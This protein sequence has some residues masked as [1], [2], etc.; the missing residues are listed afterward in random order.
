MSSEFRG[1]EITA[2]ILDSEFEPLRLSRAFESEGDRKRISLSISSEFIEKHQV[3]FKQDFKEEF[4]RGLGVGELF[5][6]SRSVDSVSRNWTSSF[7][8]LYIPAGNF[9]SRSSII[10]TISTQSRNSL[11]DEASI[12]VEG[13][14]YGGGGNV[15]FQ[16]TSLSMLGKNDSVWSFDRLTLGFG[17]EM[18]WHR[19]SETNSS[20][21]NGTYVFS[22]QTAPRL[23]TELLSVMDQE[24]RVIVESITSF[25]SFRRNQKFR[26]LG[27]TPERIRE[28]GGGAAQFSILSGSQ[29][30]NTSQIEYAS[31]LQSSYQLRNDIGISLGI[32]YENQSNINDNSNFAP[33]FGVAWKPKRKESQNLLWSLPSITAGFGLFYS[34]FGIENKV[35]L[36]RTNDSGGDS[37][38]ITD[39]KILDLFPNRIVIENEGQT[40]LQKNK[41]TFNSELKTPQFLIGNV[42]ITKLLPRKFVFSL[43]YKLSKKRRLTTIRNI[44]SP[45]A[46]SYD[47]NNGMF[48]IFPNGSREQV[49]DYGSIG[50]QNSA[51]FSA[52]LRFPRL[53]VFF[54]DLSYASVRYAFERSKSNIVLGS[55]SPFDP[56][57]FR[58]EFASD[59][60]DGIHRFSALINFSFRKDIQL[61]A[62]WVA[63]TGS[64]FNLT[65]GIDSNG[66]GFFLERPSFVTDRLIPGAILTKYGLLNPNPL[67]GE[68]LIPRNLGRGPFQSKLDLFVTKWLGFI[69]SKSKSNA[70]KLRLRLFAD[71]LNVL[72]FN[73]K[74]TPIGNMS[75]PNFLESISPNEVYRLGSPSNAR[76]IRFGAGLY[77]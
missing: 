72:N 34:R 47:I 27:Y 18:L 56:Y 35:N 54:G 65:T 23:N 20:N 77:F 30:F 1:K 76:R 69:K 40:S 44:N 29:A 2:N 31:Y 6:E 13:A 53:K 51:V 52:N 39:P 64:R 15:G 17:G 57:D 42:D 38:L 26:Q 74:S 43:R 73:G 45:I 5:L 41:I 24:G 33:R 19:W 32:R 46:R 21:V 49:L 12:N 66:D 14:F 60:N 28:F 71:F 59:S 62:S 58:N 55:G 70:P 61:N 3:F 11:S 63:R 16:N 67:Q 50:K 9:Y 22:G 10:G 8:D 37:Y 48:G 68:S 75:S 25:E 4:G 7:S 36:V